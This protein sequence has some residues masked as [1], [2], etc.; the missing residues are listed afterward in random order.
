MPYNQPESSL[1]LLE[2]WISGSGDFGGSKKDKERHG[3]QHDGHGH[4]R[5]GDL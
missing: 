5:D 1:D 4:G 2:H 3:G